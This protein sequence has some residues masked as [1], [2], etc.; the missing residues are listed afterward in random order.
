LVPTIFDPLGGFPFLAL[1]VELLFV[2]V[3]HTLPFPPP[4]AWKKRRAMLCMVRGGRQKLPTTSTSSGHTY[5]EAE[6]AEA[7]EKLR[8]TEE[9]KALRKRKL[10]ERSGN[11]GKL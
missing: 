3:Y 7:A 6:K 5:H 1:S 11:D 2:Y 9:R 8:L 4:V 10:E